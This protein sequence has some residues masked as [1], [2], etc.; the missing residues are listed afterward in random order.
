MKRFHV[1]V[2]VDDLAKSIAFYSK[3]FAADPARV[4]SD[5]AKWMLDDPRVNFAI[6]T[7]GKTPGLD[8]LG[9]QVDDASELA[10]LKAAR[11]RPTWPCSTRA[12]RPAATHAVR[13]TGSTTRKASPG[14]TSTLW[15]T[16]PSSTKR[17]RRPGQERAARHKRLTLPPAV[18]LL[19][20]LE[21]KRRQVARLQAA[22]S[23]A[24]MAMATF[25]R[26]DSSDFD[27]V[28]GLLTEAN[29][30]IGD[31]TPSSM[32][33]F[34]GL[35]VDGALIAVGGLEQYGSAGLLRSVAVRPTLRRSGIGA[36]L[37]AALEEDARSRNLLQLALLTTTAAGFF[38]NLGYAPT[39]RSS[40]PAALQSSAEFASICP[41]SAACLS[42]R[43]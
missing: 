19:R 20:Q 14:S 23:A 38:E 15:A 31:L 41:V 40:L 25:E 37:V 6:S 27:E 7:R 8:H 5:Y 4:E 11:N 42:K 21:Q 33:G 2:H 16:S 28:L 1:H 43:F 10:E 18:R 12:P 9:F 29:L 30:P 24:E 32:G 13:N 3:L 39:D 26:L 34:L 17:K 22:P 35:R 36:Q